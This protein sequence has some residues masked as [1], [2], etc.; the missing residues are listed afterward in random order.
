ME[1]G[2]PRWARFPLT[3]EVEAVLGMDAVGLGKRR[4][5]RLVGTDDACGGACLTRQG[6]P[7]L[8]AQTRGVG[9]HIQDGGCD[10]A[11]PQEEGCHHSV[12]GQ[13]HHW[14]YDQRLHGG[15]CGTRTI[16]KG[17]L[18]VTSISN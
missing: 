11:I 1:E 16:H 10:F 3:E 15:D 4:V 17:N 18:Q 8:I 2:C 5:M 6:E 7:N 12:C 14:C 13:S 9:A